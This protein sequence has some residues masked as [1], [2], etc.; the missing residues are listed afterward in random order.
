LRDRTGDSFS[1]YVNS[2]NCDD[3]DGEAF[4]LADLNGEYCCLEWMK[5]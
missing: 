2:P 5:Y 1:L 3:F 4:T